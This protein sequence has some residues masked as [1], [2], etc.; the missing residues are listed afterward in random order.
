VKLADLDAEI[1]QTERELERQRTDHLRA[2][3][4]PIFPQAAKKLR[5]RRAEILASIEEKRQKLGVTPESA[6]LTAEEIE[7]RENRTERYAYVVEKAWAE[8]VANRLE[9]LRTETVEERERRHARLLGMFTS[10]HAS[11]NDARFADADDQAHGIAH[12]D[13]QKAEE[14]AAR[15]GRNTKAAYSA[16]YDEAWQGAY[17]DPAAAPLFLPRPE[18][19]EAARA[20]LAQVIEA[21]R[22]ELAAVDLLGN[23]NA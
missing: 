5:E 9:R 21:E 6:A 10:M 14:R 7:R 12:R 20:D 13:G 2:L 19:V 16:A 1:E 4:H 8:S 3:S 22:R 23:L 17:S 15:I 11:L 18:D